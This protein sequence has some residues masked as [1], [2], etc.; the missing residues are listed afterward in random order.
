MTYCYITDHSGVSNL[1]SAYVSYCLWN[2]TTP[3]LNAILPKQL[4]Q[5][6]TSITEHKQKSHSFYCETIVFVKMRK[7][8]VWCKLLSRL[9]V[10]G[11]ICICFVFVFQMR[12]RMCV[13]ACECVFS[14]ECRAWGWMCMK[15]LLKGGH[16]AGAN[17]ALCRPTLLNR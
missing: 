5:N 4:L 12:L 15:R 2:F 10:C 3:C 7:R 16:E 1:A 11:K 17:L 6:W 8:F 14:P 13:R 9:E